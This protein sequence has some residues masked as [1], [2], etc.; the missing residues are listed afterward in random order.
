MASK[1]TVTGSVF[2]A[3]RSHRKLRDLPKC[4]QLGRG[5]ACDTWFPTVLKDGSKWHPLP[6]SPYAASFPISQMQQIQARISPC[7]FF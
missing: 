1:S 2:A 6:G 5:K 3:P 7:F 4:T